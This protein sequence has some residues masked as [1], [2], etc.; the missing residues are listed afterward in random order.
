[1]MDDNDK[2][3]PKKAQQDLDRIMVDSRP[4]LE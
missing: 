2:A 1:M 3:N 4:A